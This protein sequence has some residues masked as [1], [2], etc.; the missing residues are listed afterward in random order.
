V[1]R[2]HGPGFAPLRRAGGMAQDGR[3]GVIRPARVAGGPAGNGRDET[4]AMG[5]DPDTGRPGA[6]GSGARTGGQH[7][8]SRRCPGHL[9]PTA[10]V[11]ALISFT[12]HLPL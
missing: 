1:K 10:S 2:A 4:G 12:Y 8:V 11:D 7:G 9:A 3:T 5:R 6:C